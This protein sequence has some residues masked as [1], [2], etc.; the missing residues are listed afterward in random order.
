MKGESKP[1]YAP[2]FL[3]GALCDRGRRRERLA[4]FLQVS[5][6]PSHLQKG[7]NRLIFFSRLLRFDAAIFCFLTRNEMI[8]AQGD[9][10]FCFILWSPGS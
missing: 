9:F 6:W 8:A 2:P 3:L 5:F 10:G 7:L 4:K 1:E